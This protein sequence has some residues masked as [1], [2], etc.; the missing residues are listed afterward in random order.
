ME[1]NAYCPPPK[2]SQAIY[3]EPWAMGSNP[4]WNNR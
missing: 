1:R 4:R 3:V 2:I